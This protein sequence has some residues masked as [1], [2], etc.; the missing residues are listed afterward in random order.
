MKKQTLILLAIAS[1]M[2]A[3]HKD[4]TQQSND[5]RLKQIITVAYSD[6]GYYTTGDVVTSNYI[7]EDS[8]CISEGQTILYNGDTITIGFYK[9]I[10]RNGR[11]EEVF[12]T[13]PA[14]NNYHCTYSYDSE[15]RIESS[16]ATMDDDVPITTT[17]TW[18]NGNVIKTHTEYYLFP[19]EKHEYDNYYTYDNKLNPYKGSLLPTIKSISRNNLLED[20]KITEYDT[21]RFVYS[22]TYKGDYPVIEYFQTIT[23]NPINPIIPTKSYI[24]Y[25]D[26][27][28]ANIPQFCTITVPQHPE[29]ADACGRLEMG[30]G[31]YEY[32]ATVILSTCQCRPVRWSDGSTDNPH[33]V[34]ARGDATYTVIYTDK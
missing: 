13:D 20:V 11:V 16:V 14:T 6:N 12:N 34:I 4:D 8:L 23:S 26:G 3:C 22:Y 28:S 21:T 5:K 31:K 24:V 25:M 19:N 33:T 29:N 32:G 30:G 1:V 27:T 9:I 18:N 7:W 17:Y 15:G 10:K 2:V